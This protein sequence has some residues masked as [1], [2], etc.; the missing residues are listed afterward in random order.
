[1]S[2]DMKENRQYTGHSIATKLC[3]KFIEIYIMEIKAKTESFRSP[4]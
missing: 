3:K 2:I 4:S 1:M